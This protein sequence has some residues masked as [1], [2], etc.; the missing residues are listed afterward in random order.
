MSLK[1]L[2]VASGLSG[3]SG[4]ERYV[5]D[6]APALRRLGHE[7]TVACRPGSEVERCAAALGLPVLHWEMYWPHDWRQLPRFIRAMRGR[8][9]VAHT[10]SYRDY[11]VPAAAA[12]LAGVPV[13]VLTRHNPHPFRNRLTAYVCSELFYDGIIAVSEFVQK[14]LVEGGAAPQRIFLVKNGID[15]EAWQGA[16]NRYFREE[17]KIPPTAFLV[18]VSGHLN[19]EK[20]IHVLIRAVAR[21]QERG[22]AI[23]CAIAGEGHMRAELENLTAQ[24]GVQDRVR[25]LGFRRDIPALFAAADAVA[26]PSTGPEA[27]PYCMVEALASGRPVI[28]S[29]VGGIPEMI[30]PDTGLLVDAGDAEGLAHAIE[31]LAFDASR[32]IAM[33]EAARRRAQDLTLDACVRGIE[34]VY[35]TLM[36][37][38]RS[39]AHPNRLPSGSVIRRG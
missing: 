32:R 11:L 31:E 16:T 10:H 12:Q 7:V 36:R 30:N 19:P 24:L 27:F 37:G 9:D 14:L 28:A 15:L 17:L 18:A 29:R 13:V 1:I 3:W 5:I 20:G 26:I 33:G 8:F 35:E 4:A 25:L 39:V 34:A 23:F 21:A 2:Q 22:G 38:S 6:I